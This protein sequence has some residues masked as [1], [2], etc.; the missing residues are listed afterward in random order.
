MRGKPMRSGPMVLS[1]SAIQHRGHLS[2][3]S[4]A[5]SLLEKLAAQLARSALIYIGGAMHFLR[6]IE[7]TLYAYT[8]YPLPYSHLRSW[9]CTVQHWCSLDRRSTSLRLGSQSLPKGTAWNYQCTL[10]DLILNAHAIRGET[11]PSTMAIVF[12]VSVITDLIPNCLSKFLQCMTRSSTD[13]L[14]ELDSE[15]ELTLRRLRKVRKTVVNN[16]SISSSVINS[17]QFPTDNSISS[18][19]HFAEPRQMENNDRT[20]KELAT[21]N[22]PAQ[23][24]ELKSGLIH[25]LPKFH[26][27]VGKDP[28]KHLKEFHVVCSTMRPYKGLA[29]P[30]ANTFQHLGRHETHLSREV[31]SSI[32]N[33]IHLKGNMWDKEKLYMNTGRD[34]T[35]S[36]PPVHTTRS[37][38]SY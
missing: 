32:Q 14:Y 12:T 19:S 6:V 30:S 38:S 23:T 8:L 11:P 35:S 36:M 34:L 15:I 3:S 10:V 13:P 27:L 24:Y 16:S 22:V 18:F 21:P 31:L 26:G 37:A 28:H 5:T 25:L 1:T 20:L 29:V 33:C 9:W 17:N 4:A 7:F 2:Y